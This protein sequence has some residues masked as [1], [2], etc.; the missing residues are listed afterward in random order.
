VWLVL[1][2]VGDKRK[3]RDAHGSGMRC[4][5]CCPCLSVCWE[6]QTGEV[7]DDGFSVCVGLGCSVASSLSLLLNCF[8]LL[9]LFL[10]KSF[11]GKR[12]G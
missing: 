4:Y 3:R 6:R 11:W 1:P 2:L 12:R 8:S 5:L 10:L 9:L 7:G